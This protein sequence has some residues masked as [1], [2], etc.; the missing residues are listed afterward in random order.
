MENDPTLGLSHIAANLDTRVKIISHKS[1]NQDEQETY[2]TFLRI[3][4]GLDSIQVYSELCISS[5]F[6]PS[7]LLQMPIVGA[8]ALVERGPPVG[9][10]GAAAQSE[11]RNAVTSLVAHDTLRR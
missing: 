11:R 10:F 9:R 4:N 3:T 6:L 8:R 5:L 1:S 2:L 7:M